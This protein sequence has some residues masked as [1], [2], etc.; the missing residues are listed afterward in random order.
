LQPLDEMRARDKLYT[1]T[2]DV[3]FGEEE[4]V[5]ASAR[6]SRG[7]GDGVCSHGWNVDF[8]RSP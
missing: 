6:S 4:R 3:E 2:R 7:A 1:G 5:S 8:D